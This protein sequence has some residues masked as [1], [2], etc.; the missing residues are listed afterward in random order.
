M[1][2]TLPVGALFTAPAVAQMN[3]EVMLQWMDTEVVHW[4]VVG[5]YEGE[6]M[7]VQSGTNG[8]APV[9]DHVEIAFDYD[10]TQGKLVGAAVFTD[11]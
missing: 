9:K 10:I 7:I 8:Y 5:D 11:F 1:L 2:V 4:S 3:Q 6:A